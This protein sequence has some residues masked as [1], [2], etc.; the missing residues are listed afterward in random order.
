MTRLWRDLPKALAR[1]SPAA[2]LVAVL[3]LALA[4]GALTAI[5]SLLNAVVL[6]SLPVPHAEQLAGLATTIPDD[7]NGDQPISL[8]MF[9]ELRRQNQV[10][11]SL[12][13]WTGGGISGRRQKNRPARAL[14]HVVQPVR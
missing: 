14:Q 3:T 5:F 4:M 6:R 9:L 8:P 12:F 11:S 1:R 7:V 10:F 13:A 2:T